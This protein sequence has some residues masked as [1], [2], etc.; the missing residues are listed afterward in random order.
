MYPL[1]L[2][3]ILVQDGNI[4]GEKSSTAGVTDEK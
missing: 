3:R 1:S 2:S 4:H